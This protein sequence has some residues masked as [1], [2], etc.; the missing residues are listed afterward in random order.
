MGHD[1]DAGSLGGC[2]SSP[3]AIPSSGVAGP[4]AME[5]GAWFAGNL[6]HGVLTLPGGGDLLEVGPYR[7][8]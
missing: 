4:Q 1:V 6:H 2:M 5:Q 8:S 3:P 7:G